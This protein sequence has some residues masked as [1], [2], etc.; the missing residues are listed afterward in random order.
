MTDLTAPLLA[1]QSRLLHAIHGI[2]E[3]DLS[4]LEKEGGWSILDVVAH[5]GDVELLT[6]WRMRLMLAEDEP[7]LPRF[8]QEQWLAR[9]HAGET[10]AE[11]LEV[12]WSLR[13]QNVRLIRSLSDAE[14]QRHAL[15]PRLGRITVAELLESLREHQERHLDQLE[16]IKRTLGLKVSTVVDVSG[17]VSA[18]R[19]GETRSPGPGVRVYDL[20]SDGVRRALQV[21]LDAGAQWPGLDYHVPGPEEV[22][23]VSGDFY[24]GTRRYEAGTFL[25]H[26]AGSSHSPASENGCVLFVFH[27]EG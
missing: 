6:A 1:F 5:L 14:L 4:R 11:R 3:H 22:F 13:R 8:S 7:Q 25:H 18:S 23:V 10:L 9:L 19:N 21:E 17:V 27:G 15:H 24:D 2:A 20:W 12:F 26:P 16:R